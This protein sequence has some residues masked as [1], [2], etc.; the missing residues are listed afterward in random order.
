MPANLP[1]QYFEAEKKFRLAKNPADKKV[2]LEEML[3]I[4]PKHKGT[5]HLR[6]DL[7]RKIARLTQISEK[8]AA[9]QRASMLIDK[10]GA[11]QVVVVGLPNTGKSQLV[12]SVTNA[13]P[14]VAEYPFTTQ[15]AT[16]GMMEFENI[17]IQLIDTP[18]LT[19]Q[20]VVWW[21]PHMIRRADALLIVVDLGDAPLAQVEAIFTELESRKIDIKDKVKALIVGNKLDL[22]SA[23]ENHLALKNKY[24]GQLPV[25]AV[26]ARVGVGLEEMKR[27]IFQML[28]IIRVYTKAPGQKPEFTDPIILERGSTLE[29]AA[30]SVH[31]DFAAKLK[32][33][34]IWGSGKHD[35]IMAKRDHV[36]QD[37]DII[38]LHL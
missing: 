8:K 29:D 12:S 3:A 34:R 9:T 26:S 32:Y 2:A 16:P 6:A 35:G 19:E 24:Q 27:E 21:L 4:M 28:D 5:D 23:Q 13:S 38:E 25:I 14:T 7:R 10:E 20:S 11:A 22:A 30:A 31:K 17:Q 15:S 37:G 18:P 36:L 1:P 33:A